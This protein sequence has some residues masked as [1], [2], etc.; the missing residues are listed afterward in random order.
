[1]ILI[2]KTSLI[3]NVGIIRQLAPHSKI[4]CMVKANAYG[5]GL[6]PIANTLETLQVEGLGVACLS[7]AIQLRKAGITTKIVIMRG[8]YNRPELEIAK[9][10]NLDLVIHHEEQVDLI[11][12]QQKCFNIWL[13]INTG[14]NRLGINVDA[15]E[16]NIKKLQAGNNHHIICMT[17]FANS[18][19]ENDEDTQA[20]IKKFDQCTHHV[21]YEKSLCNSGGILNYP[22]CH[23]DWIRPGLMLYGIS[24]VKNTTASDFGLKPVMSLESSILSIYTAKRGE[25]IGYGGLYECKEDMPIGIVGAGYG[26][27][28]SSLTKSGTPILVNHQAAKLIGRVSMDMLAI[29]LRNVSKVKLQDRVEL[30]GEDLPLEKIA[31]Y[32]SLLSYELLCHARER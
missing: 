16:K 13:K 12:S 30:W 14:M 8:V 29:D 11:A 20:Q 31:E 28:Y 5:H 25:K 7:E 9:Q 1:M 17:H 21:Q 27:G 26:D 6:I 22:E 2:N 32:N 19:K 24:P 15:I 23:R 18:E 4:L 3:H 10:L